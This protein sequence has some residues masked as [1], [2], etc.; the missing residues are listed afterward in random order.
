[1]MKVKP[2]ANRALR[3]A[4]VVVAAL[5]APLALVPAYAATPT[6]GPG[7][8]ASQDQAENLTLT[9]PVVVELV[10][11][12][13]AFKHLPPGDFIGLRQAYYA[14]DR[15]TSTY[16]AAAQVVPSPSAYTA[17]VASQDDGGYTVFHKPARSGW[18]AVDDG[19]G[20]A[21]GT[22]C[23][24]YHVSI[25]AAVLAVWYWGAGRCTPTNFGSGPL[26]LTY[27]AQARGQWS[28]GASAIS[29]KQAQY[30]MA[31]A[32]D[33]EAALKAKA[34]GT[35]GYSAAA[36]ELAELSKLP[37]AMQTSAQAKEDQALTSA[38]N[39][40]FGTNGL[41]GWSAPST[42]T[43][44]FVSTL[45]QEADLGT[46]SSNLVADPSL[47]HVPSN[48]TFAP[49]S[50]PVVSGV[51]AGSVFGCKLDTFVAYYFVGTVRTADATNY[52]GFMVKGSAFFNCKSDGL[53]AAEQQAA[54]K[55]GGGC[56]A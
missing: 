16:W 48:F 40:F 33:L 25:P 52:G 56:R 54:K 15:A 14:Y 39:N 36:T 6:R 35:T 46:L 13:A 28:T 12:D 22:Q 21:A 34:P 42:T 37:D 32:K 19:M 51:T 55:L 27:L 23:S 18:L 8:S 10:D 17:L 11:A 7:A 1:M 4:S 2:V 47:D 30:W 38:L 5:M 9:G 50:C 26:L 20:G 53:S 3:V 44:A 49:L 45:Q 24:A 29:A 41:Y 43:K 31:A